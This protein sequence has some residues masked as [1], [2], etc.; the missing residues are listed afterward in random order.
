MIRSLHCCTILAGLAIASACGSAR[1]EMG[2]N[3]AGGRASAGGASAGGTSSAGGGVASAGGII[4][5]GFGS[6]TGSF[7]V[8]P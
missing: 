3:V 4:S 7:L 5:N 6:Y 1:I 8:V 2:G